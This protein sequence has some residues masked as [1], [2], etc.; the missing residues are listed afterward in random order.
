MIAG[1]VGA[2]FAHTV[3]DGPLIL[4]ALVAMVAG[5]VSFLSP[6]VLPL[7][8]GY[9]S[10]VTGLAGSE[11]STVDDADR[12]DGD[13]SGVEPTAAGAAKPT[14]GVAVAARPK[15]R[16]AWARGGR[17]RTG[18]S[19]RRR[20]F[21]GSALF[22][23]G[24]TAVF[25]SYG[26]AFGGLGRA[27]YVHQHAIE[28][29]LGAVTILLGLAFVGLIPGMQ[30]DFRIHKLPQTGLLGAPVLGVLFGLGWT[31]CIGPTLGAV[32]TLAFSSAS[33]GRGAFLSVA[34]CIGLGVPFV[35]AAF[36]FRWVIGAFGV[37]RRHAIWVTRFG[38]A[39]LV[40][41]GIVIVGGWW[42]EFMTYF[43]AWV[44][45]HGGIGTLL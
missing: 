14:G 11:Q 32:Q 40:V 38:G 7:V 8:P 19:G 30:R 12:T 31:P 22:V 26:A 39:L 4:G 23:L 29:G 18:H 25:V 37:V 1:G 44:G 3:A 2:S 6:C 42:D 36:G 15:A 28:R 43:R 16:V 35:L 33:A 9:L 17:S 10:Y 34:Y 45:S 20:T 27:L 24:F 5:L 41:L 13:A 21:A